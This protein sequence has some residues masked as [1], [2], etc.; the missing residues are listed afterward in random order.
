[1]VEEAGAAAAAA[2][3]GP[4][5]LSAAG[6]VAGA[7]RVVGAGSCTSTVAPP[8]MHSQ[9]GEPQAA[10]RGA[11][12]VSEGGTMAKAVA[13]DWAS[14]DTAGEMVGQAAATAAWVAATATAAAEGVAAEAGMVAV[15]AGEATW[16]AGAAMAVGRG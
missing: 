1:L 11:R 4:G 7:E 15:A 2:V 10:R 16:G 13:G 5:H 14:P 8:V 12:A 3:E 9:V 6:G